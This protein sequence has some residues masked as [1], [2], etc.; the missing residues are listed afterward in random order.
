MSWTMARS[1][2]PA[3]PRRNWLLSEAAARC[4]SSAQ[5][6]TLTKGTDN[7]SGSISGTGGLILTGGSQTLSG[8]NLYTGATTVNGGTLTVTGSILKSAGVTVNSAASWR[9]AARCRP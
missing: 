6:L 8:A 9:A 7:F 4:C 2:F 1:I 3:P 5:T